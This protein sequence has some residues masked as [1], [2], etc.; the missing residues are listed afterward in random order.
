VQCGADY[1]KSNQTSPVGLDLV[2]GEKYASFDGDADR[3]VYYFITQ[4]E[5]DLTFFIF[6]TWLMRILGEEAVPCFNSNWYN[7]EYKI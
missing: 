7:I 4:G 5:S 3:I 1:V 2:P 6:L